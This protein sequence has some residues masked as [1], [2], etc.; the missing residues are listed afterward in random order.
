MADHLVWAHIFALARSWRLRRATPAASRGAVSTA[1]RCCRV[2]AVSTEDPA[3]GGEGGP[4]RGVEHRGGL[5][6]PGGC[7]EQQVALAAERAFDGRRHRFLG[8]PHLGVGER[9][10]FGGCTEV[11]ETGQAPQLDRDQPTHRLA[12]PAV[13]RPVIPH[14]LLDALVAGDDVHQQEAHRRRSLGRGQH[15]GI[16]RRLSPERLEPLGGEQ[17]VQVDREME[18][19]DLVDS[20][21]PAVG[22]TDHSVGPA[23]DGHSPSVHRGFEPGRD[24]CL[25]PRFDRGQLFLDPAVERAADPQAGQPG[26]GQADHALRTLA[27]QVA[28]ARRD[29][30][31]FRIDDHRH[32]GI[33]MCARG[34]NPS[35]SRRFREPDRLRAAGPGDCL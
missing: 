19:L 9:Q 11:V 7:G 22:I 10:G 32:A 28:H 8:G 25:E 26:S 4:Q 5:A 29:R 2:L 30:T 24:L 13:D 1:S 12:Y 34:R 35:G 33:L 20:H 21:D 23:G 17:I 15:R 14:H 18:G 16:Q 27:D 3:T 6:D 31:M